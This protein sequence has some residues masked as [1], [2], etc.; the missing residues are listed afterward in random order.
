MSFYKYRISFQ[1]IFQAFAIS[2]NTIIWIDSFRYI[3]PS[4]DMDSCVIYEEGQIITQTSTFTRTTI[5]ASSSTTP[6][7]PIED[8]LTE[9]F[10]NSFED[11]F[12]NNYGICVGF[13]AWDIQQY[14]SVNISSPHPGSASFIAPRYGSSCIASYKF[15]ISARGA[16]QVN[17]YMVPTSPVDQLTVTVFQSVLEGDDVPISRIFLNAMTPGFIDGWQILNVTMD[18]PDTFDTFEGYVSY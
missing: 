17:L 9:H 11:N 12:T 6:E 18:R 4:L 8:C 14:S 16:I 5:A 2:P 15:M 13:S 3:G 1:I 10:E 7:E